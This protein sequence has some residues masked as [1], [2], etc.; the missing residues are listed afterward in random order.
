[1]AKALTT[2]AVEAAKPDPAKRY[3]VPDPA[4]SGL[5]LVVQSSGVKSWALRY[6]FGG[7]PAKLTLAGR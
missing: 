7:K 3:E 5:Y 4:L 6:R 1:M 2:K